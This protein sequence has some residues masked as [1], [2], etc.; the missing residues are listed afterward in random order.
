M[1]QRSAQTNIRWV[2]ARH[3]RG[4]AAA[5]DFRREAV[6]APGLRWWSINLKQI[7]V[8][9]FVLWDY[10]HL[11]DC[12]IRQLHA[13]WS[14]GKIKS[15]EHCYDG[16]D[17]AAQGLLSVMSGGNFGKAIVRVSAGE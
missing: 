5:S 4:N 1:T 14:A 13:W 16:I 15:R 6:P 2:L 12:Y 8:E 9:G 7:R 11:Y 3:P 17:A 10:E